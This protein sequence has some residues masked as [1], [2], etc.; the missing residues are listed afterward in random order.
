MNI[1]F[2]NATTLL[3]TA[4]YVGLFAFVFMETGLLI[5]L[6]LPGETL[7]F[8]A[9]FLSSVG[10]FNIFAVIGIV[11]CAAV[12]A[13]STEY[14]LGK[15]Y[16]MK[17]FDREKSLFFDKEYVNQAEDF[18][19]KHGGKTIFLARFIPFVRTLAPLFA[20]IG[21]M[22]YS[23]FITYNVV[24]AFIWATCISLLGYFFGKIVPNADQY[25]LW[26]VLGV[27][28]ISLVPPAAAFF[29]SKSRRQRV[30]VFLRERIQHEK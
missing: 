26:L 19:K 29:Q 10:D 2:F 23:L 13:D 7:V 8:T 27:A 4:G 25:A 21:N 15:K 9:G 3:L 24:G 5:G 1:N 30:M 11:F 6:I 14:F 17:V 28:L 16:G 20:G 12:L 22:R 18:Y